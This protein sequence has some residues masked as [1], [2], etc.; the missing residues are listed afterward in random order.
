M[1]IRL[2]MP[3]VLLLVAALACSSSKSTTEPADVDVSA[4]Q[5]SA[6]QTALADIADQPTEVEQIATLSPTE[7]TISVTEPPAPTSTKVPTST[8]PPTMNLDLDQFIE[9]YNDSTD[10][11]KK[12]FVKE[13]IGQWVRWSG[14]VLD[15]EE[16][17]TVLIKI[18]GTLVSSISIKGISK[19]DAININK[20]QT[21][22]FTGQI[23]DIIDL[24]GLHIYIEKGQLIP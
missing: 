19:Q 21:I 22:T 16:D 10:A 6:V 8:T 7:E 18:P 15:V 2:I 5:T 11:Q 20:K 4:I 1:K 12:V 14:E 13:S 9:K 17:N 24:L 23:K 3:A